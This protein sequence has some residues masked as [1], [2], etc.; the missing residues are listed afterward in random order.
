MISY[1][2]VKNNDNVNALVKAADDALSALG[3]TE[4]GAGHLERVARSVGYILSSLGYDEHEIEIGRIAGYLHDIGNAVNRVDHSQSGA[5]LAYS[6]LDKMGMPV[7]D[8]APII[9][10]IGNHDEGT[11]NPVSDLAAALIIADKSDVCAKRVRS[12]D[13]DDGDIHDRVNYSVKSYEL[14]IDKEAS[15]LSVAFISDLSIASVMDFF[16][17]FTERMILCKKACEKLGLS[18]SVLINGERVA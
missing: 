3:Y 4:H 5:I 7:S 6:L 2:D 8:I 1:V 12:A 14:K 17:I 13:F 16:E 15:S 18:F 9:S 11:G 10:A